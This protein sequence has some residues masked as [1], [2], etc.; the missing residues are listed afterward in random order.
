MF[1]LTAARTPAMPCQANALSLSRSI[2]INNSLRIDVIFHAGEADADAEI[3][4][5]TCVVAE[6]D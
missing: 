3:P 1:G 6:V 5:P 2:E 4:A